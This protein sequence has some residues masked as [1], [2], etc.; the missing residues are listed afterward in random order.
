MCN[1]DIPVDPTVD[2]S[3]QYCTGEQQQQQ[4]QQ[5]KT[6]SPPS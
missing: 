6:T 2:P 4:Q 5:Q 1:A 3:K